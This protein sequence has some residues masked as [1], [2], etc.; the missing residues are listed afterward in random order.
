MIPPAMTPPP[1]PT[2]IQDARDAVASNQTWYHTMELAPGVVTPGW[3]DLRPVLDR[4]PWPDV[5]GKRCL[6]VGTYDGHLAFELE[7][8]GAS[9]V[10]ATDIERH[11][12]WDWPLR[13]RE[14]TAR[15][16]WRIAGESKG[17]GFE[18]AKRILGSEVEREWISIYDLSPERLGTF[19]VVVCGSLLL[20]LRDPVRALEAIRGVCKPD[21]HF[22]SAEQIDLDLTVAHPRSPVARFDGNSE[23]LHWWTA[24]SAGHRRMLESAGFQIE[25]SSGLWANP[26]GPAHPPSPRNLKMLRKAAMRRTLAGGVGIPSST[27]LAKPDPAV[28]A[29][30]ASAQG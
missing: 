13:H 19:D 16:L 17:K 25:R 11:L 18:I 7:R 3:F 14:T 27:L 6:D 22:M 23:L 4:Q 28:P 8:R 29:E 30:A 2:E 21:G 20:H 10:T 15:E 26:L 9:E 1:Q 5:R 12:D 24:N